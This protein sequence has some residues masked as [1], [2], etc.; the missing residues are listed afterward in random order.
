MTTAAI[1]AD[2]RHSKFTVMDARYCDNEKTNLLFE[3]WISFIMCMNDNFILCKKLVG[4]HLSSLSKKVNLVQYK[5]HHLY[6]KCAGAL[7][8]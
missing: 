5:D 1:Q 7:S 6:I 2:E 4:K 3:N 8:M